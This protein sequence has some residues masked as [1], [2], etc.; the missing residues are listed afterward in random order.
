MKGVPTRSRPPPFGWEPEDAPEPRWKAQRKLGALADPDL[1]PGSRTAPALR[2]LRRARWAQ[3]ETESAAEP[4]PGKRRRGRPRKAIAGVGPAPEAAPSL[5]THPAPPER[6]T[7]RFHGRPVVTSA[8][9]TRLWAARRRNGKRVYRLELEEAAVEDLL[10]SAGLLQLTGADNH[11]AVEQ[12]LGR[13][14]EIMV[15]DDRTRG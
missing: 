7:E 3:D 2:F 12:A 11:H 5:K 10:V 6:L 1:Q 13:L 8:A 14:V 15:E 4:I 9:R